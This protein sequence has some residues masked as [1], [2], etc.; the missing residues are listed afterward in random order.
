MK[1]LLVGEDDGTRELE[2]KIQQCLD[3][4]GEITTVYPDNLGDKLRAEKFDLVLMDSKQ[5]EDITD[6]REMEN[7][8]QEREA[9]LRRIT[10]NMEV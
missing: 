3:A 6:Q 4:S 5:A 7:A 1:Y 9:T 10:D 2:S 8:L